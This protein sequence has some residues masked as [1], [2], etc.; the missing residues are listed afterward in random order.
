MSCKIGEFHTPNAVFNYDHRQ[1]VRCPTKIDLS[2]TIS[3]GK[4][5]NRN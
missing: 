5:I 1:D 3:G 4:S 2:P